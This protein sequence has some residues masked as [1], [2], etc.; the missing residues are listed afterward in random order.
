M[1]HPT[2]LRDAQAEAGKLEA[3]KDDG[4]WAA[5]EAG[6]GELKPVGNEGSKW[7]YLATTT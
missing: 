3:A 5:S 6:D 1:H 7:F 2:A 4:Q